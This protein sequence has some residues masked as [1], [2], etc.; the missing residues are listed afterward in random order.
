MEQKMSFTSPQQPR[1]SEAGQNHPND[2]ASAGL[3]GRAPPLAFI[4]EAG[5]TAPAAAYFNRIR[6]I[7]VLQSG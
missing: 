4:S 3:I 7:V 5:P 2:H 6:P 1:T